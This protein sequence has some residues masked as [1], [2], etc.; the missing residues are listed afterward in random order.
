MPKKIDDF[1]LILI[2]LNA[3]IP[4]LLI[5]GAISYG[6]AKITG[7]HNPKKYKSI[8]SIIPIEDLNED[9][10][11]ELIINY[12]SGK[13]DTIYSDSKDKNYRHIHYWF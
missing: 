9:N 6:L 1:K 11:P 10:F 3:M 8:E 4:V 2:G 13:I 12:K 7:H 5:V